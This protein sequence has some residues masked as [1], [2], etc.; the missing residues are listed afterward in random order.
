VSQPFVALTLARYG[1]MLLDHARG[2]DRDR[3]RVLL[4]E[5]ASIASALGMRCVVPRDRDPQEIPKLGDA[6]GW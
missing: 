1:R 4:G 5:A 6:A 3:A 2:S